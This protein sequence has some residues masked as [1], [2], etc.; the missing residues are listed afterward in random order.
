MHEEKRPQDTSQRDESAIGG[1]KLDGD[2]AESVVDSVQ[3][4]SSPSNNEVADA[5]VEDIQVSSTTT[6]TS[7]GD[8]APP[9][10]SPDVPTTLPPPSSGDV[11]S[12]SGDLSL[13]TPTSGV[14]V[15]STVVVSPETDSNVASSPSILV[16]N[17]SNNNNNGNKDGDGNEEGGS[18]D[19]SGTSDSS[20]D[21][22]ESSSNSSSSGID[23]TL[24]DEALSED[25][26][27][28]SRAGRE[29]LGNEGLPK[30]GE[31]NHSSVLPEGE[32]GMKKNGGSSETDHTKLSQRPHSVSSPDH[33]TSRRKVR[34]ISDPDEFLIH[35]QDILER[36]HKI[37]Y[38]RY[39]TIYPDGVD[40]TNSNDTPTGSTH[41]DLDLKQII[42]EHRQ[43]ILKD[44]RILFTGV[45]PTN[46]P[47]RKNPEW[48]T[49][50]AFGATIHTSLVPGLNSSKE[51]DVLS[52]TTH[53]IAGKPGTTKLLEA[54]RMPGVKI[55]NPHWLWACAEC[56]KKVDEEKF[57]A[58]A[59]KRQSGDG[60]RQST[61]ERP[62]L[63]EAGEG[64]NGLNRKEL[65]GARETIES[66]LG[67]K[68]EHES[69]QD[70]DSE[71]DD[72]FKKSTYTELARMDTTEL[73][74]HLSM[75]SRLSVSDAELEKMD[76]EVDA[77]ISSS[78]EAEGEREELG[79]HVELIDNED[80]LSYEKF[81]GTHA[82]QDIDVL[83]RL[84]RKRTFADLEASSS[85]ES[86]IVEQLNESF[87]S[88]NDMGEEESGEEEDELGALLGF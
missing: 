8:G 35:L 64:G 54:R 87:V 16:N 68:P 56:W 18:K 17:N 81:A 48:N 30:E 41:T 55:V 49:A 71:D 75:E 47:T 82:S 59:E 3:A 28:E 51:E 20:S 88:D 29:P 15:S 80:N 79:S 53:V 31:Q 14:L 70:S 24:F 36:I 44:C 72:I 77:E 58:V 34:E 25:G 26:G 65:E 42:P 52:A 11:A 66:V 63:T 33:T 10:S 67:S 69:D 9:I 39:D 32:K 2:V 27:E 23:D 60:I 13:E 43:S 84:R 22:G 7:P 21:S 5:G 57:P 85:S 50:R 76:A 40:A 1:S 78:S 74:R 4:V 61:K 46:M 6:T 73:K 45:I 12:T 19:E 38:E 37:F 62:K 86:L 83:E